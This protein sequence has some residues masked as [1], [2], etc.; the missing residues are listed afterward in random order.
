[1]KTTCIFPGV[2][3]L[4]LCC[5]TFVSRES[6]SAPAAPLISARQTQSPPTSSRAS[7]ESEIRLRADRYLTQKVLAVDYYRI[8]RRLAFPLGFERIPKP[9]LPVPGIPDYPWEIWMAWEIEERLNSLGWAAQWF[10]DALG[11][12][13][14]NPGARG[15]NPLAGVHTQRQARS[16]PRP[17]GTNPLPGLRTMEPAESS[18]QRGNRLRT[19]PAGCAG[20]AL[21]GDPVWDSRGRRRTSCSHL[22]PSHRSTTFRSSV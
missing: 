1:M 14:G 12:T 13:P 11:R 5:L 19:G 7:I 9:E 6:P 2:A 10:N 21:G 8:G 3:C 4:M 18:N 17:H 22:I 16:V 20:D 15:H